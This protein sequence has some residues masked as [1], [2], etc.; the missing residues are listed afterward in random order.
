MR[1]ASKYVTRPAS[2]EFRYCGSVTMRPRIGSVDGMASVDVEVGLP[3]ITGDLEEAKRH[4]DQFGV[5]RI[6]DALSAD[7]CSAVLD[8][9]PNRRLGSGTPGSPSST[10]AAPTSGC[11]T[12]PARVG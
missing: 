4:L 8:R 9:L 2:S 10:A 12:C 3:P 7:E 5:A 11:G 1:G 6:A